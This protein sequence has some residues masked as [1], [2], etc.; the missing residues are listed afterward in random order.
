MVGGV[1]DLVG[2][3]GREGSEDGGPDPTTPRNEMR[4]TGAVGNIYGPCTHDKLPVPVG[5]VDQMSRGSPIASGIGPGH[6]F[7][8]VGVFG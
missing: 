6:I 3:D 1:S 2:G 5:F 7:P 8:S 4:T